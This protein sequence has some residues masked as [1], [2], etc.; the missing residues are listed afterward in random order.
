MREGAAV[1]SVVEG[2]LELLCSA[3]NTQMPGKE[4]LGEQT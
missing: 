4:P 1:S 2:A 3:G